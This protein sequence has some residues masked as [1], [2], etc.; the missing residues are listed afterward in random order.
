MK[1]RF[2]FGVSERGIPLG[3]AHHLAKLTDVQVE[4]IRALYEMPGKVWGYRK[5]AKRFGVSK[6]CIKNIVTFAKRSSTPAAY[7][8]QVFEV[9]AS[10]AVR[11]DWWRYGTPIDK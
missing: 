10:F 1:K 7:K 5:L 3:E 2:D 8:S 6:T 9:E 11:P 4:E